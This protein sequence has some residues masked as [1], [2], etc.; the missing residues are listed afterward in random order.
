MLDVRTFASLYH[1]Y[2]SGDGTTTLATVNESF[3]LVESR[4]AALRQSLASAEALFAE[5][6]GYYA[7]ADFADEQ[8]PDKVM[9]KFALPAGTRV[10]PDLRATLA[11][12]R[13]ALSP[14]PSEPAR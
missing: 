12:A 10:S 4:L 2:N 6:D 9:L 8:F 14:S 13:A 3:A 5:L 7:A 1:S 11:T